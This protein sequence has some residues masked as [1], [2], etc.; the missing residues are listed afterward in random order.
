MANF[1]FLSAVKNRRTY[2][3]I[4]KESTIP[5]SRVEEIVKDALTFT[6]SAFNSQSAKAVLLFGSHHEKLWEM[7]LNTLSK[8]VPPEAFEQTKQKIEAFKAG[9]GTVLYFNDESIV[10]GLQEQFALYKN[11]FPVWAQQAN[12]MLQY[13]VWVQLE[14]EGLGASLQH[15]NP[16]I[17]EA[18]RKEWNI[19]ENWK[20]IAE[21][22]FGKPTAPAGDK[23]FVPVEE[24]FKAFK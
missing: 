24:R 22:P 12:G 4:S 3:G 18:V 15:Y 11:N 1:D 9:Y 20:L 2:Y 21:M 13:S 23:S 7:T 6:P 19:P 17:D 10:K 5:D 16:L 14:L 8:I